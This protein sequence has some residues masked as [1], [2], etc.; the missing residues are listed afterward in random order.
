MK[1][2]YSSIDI[3][4]DTIKLIVSEL[5]KNKMNVLATASV[6]SKGLK[7]GLIV[8]ANETIISIKEALNE[9][10]G[11]LG[12]K[13]D[14]VIA[15]VPSYFTDFSLVNGYST[16]TNEEKE[17][18]GDDLVRTLQASVYNKL[19][20]NRELVSIIPLEFN[21]D[22][23]I[24]IRD[25]RGL[26]G[27]KLGVKALMI[28]SPKKNIYSVVSVIEAAGPEVVDITVGP[29]CDYYEHKTLETDTSI[30]AVVNIGSETT[31][32]SVFNKGVVVK[33]EV[34]QL[35]G[36]NIDRDIAYI[37]KLDRNICRE[38]KES[39]ALAHTKV[40]QVSEVYETTNLI[41]EDVKINQYEVS[42]V[43]M[44]RIV[45][46][47]NL[48]KKQINLLTNQE[49]SYIIVTGGVSEMPGFNFIL[50]DIFGD[51][52]KIGVITTIGIRNNMYSTASGIIKYFFEKLKLRGKEYSMFNDDKQRDLVSIKKRLINFS[53]DSVLGKVFGFFFE[54]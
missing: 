17:V 45:E 54:S 16:V 53:E 50:E 39:F 36:K 51:K 43:I 14:K 38:I 15:T 12:V 2:I 29:I 4:S 22:G 20:S 24:G 25:P 19:P 5:Y 10:E 3:G 41:G 13:V 31:T 48:V 21:L 32:V 11:M 42:E 30:G 1:K 37:Y 8:D 40:A 26:V 7:K 46:I 35:G 9:V 34:L 27:D 33:S 28:T 18:R 47:L 49:I 44:A 6:K 52:A 23:K